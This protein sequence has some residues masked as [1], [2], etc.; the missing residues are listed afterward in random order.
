MADQV[1]VQDAFGWWH[2]ECLHFEGF[3]TIAWETLHAVGYVA[4]PRYVTREFVEMGVTRC[5][6]RV[7]VAPHPTHPEWPPL[8]VNM[9]GHRF[10]DTVEVAAL[11]VLTSFCGHHPQA[12]VLAPVGLFPSTNMD[13][14]AWLDRL[15]HLQAAAIHAGPVFMAYWQT[16]YVNAL[17]RLQLFQQRAVRELS[18]QSTDHYLSHQLL[19][20]GFGDLS[21][22]MAD[23]ED[24]LAHR[25]TRIEE[26]EAQVEELQARVTH[27]DEQ[28]EEMLEHIA[29]MEQARIQHLQALVQME[30]ELE[31][32]HVELHD[33]QQ[34]I[35]V[36]Q[37]GGPQ[38]ME[39]D[40]PAPP[41]AEEDPDM[42]QG[43]SGMDIL[44]GVPRTPQAPAS[45]AESEASVNNLDDF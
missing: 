24:S 32:M 41:P 43:V 27:R 9:V 28:R 21:R 31:E 7:T 11:R 23:A 35:E 34:L 17:Y 10:A 6:V 33:A 36:L 3:P 2:S 1:Y 38:G 18:A 39:I 20:V 15:D 42:V 30:N 40:A 44:S 13:D 45:P 12:I 37:Q 25:Q 14:P 29:E 5:A 22:E 8:D 4:P 16:R 19:Q 26:L